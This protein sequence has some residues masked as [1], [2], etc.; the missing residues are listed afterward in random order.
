[1]THCD[2]ILIFSPFVMLAYDL[3]PQ[4]FLCWTTSVILVLHLICNAHTHTHN[5]LFG[6]KF[7]IILA[8]HISKK[9]KKM[10]IFNIFENITIFSNPECQT[11]TLIFQ[12][13]DVRYLRSDAADNQYR[14]P[15]L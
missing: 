15:I 6:S 9:L 5:L 3:C 2:Y 8:I 4:H 7:H 12:T 1:M 14:Y 11:D 13:T 10:D